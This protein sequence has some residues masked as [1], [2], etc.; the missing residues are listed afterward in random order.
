MSNWIIICFLTDNSI[1]A[2]PDTWFYKG[3]C[4]W[5]KVSKLAKKLIE[6]QIK[7]NKNDF[8]YYPARKIGNQLFSKCLFYN[9]CRYYIIYN[10][11]HKNNISCNT[12]TIYIFQ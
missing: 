6:K 10:S 1:E 4:A 3:K 8:V 2:V 11:N 7:P 9:T 5:P 12:Y